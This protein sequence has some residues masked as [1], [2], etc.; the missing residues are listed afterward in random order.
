MADHY[1]K[2]W[3]ASTTIAVANARGTPVAKLYVQE[4]E[5]GAAYIE[6]EM[7]R[8]INLDLTNKLV[9]LR[10]A[11]GDPHEEPEVMRATREMMRR[12]PP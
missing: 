4:A 1:V 10:Y 7:G 5:E 12:P 11:P 2:M 8:L 6:I 9:C 3:D